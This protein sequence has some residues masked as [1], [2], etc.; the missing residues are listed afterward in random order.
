MDVG[1]VV[2]TVVE[3]LERSDLQVSCDRQHE[4]THNLG[5]LKAHVDERLDI[6]LIQTSKLCIRL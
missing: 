5:P 3:T 6:L 1:N 4:I 2:A